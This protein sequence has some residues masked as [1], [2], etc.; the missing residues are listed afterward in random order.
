[1]TTVSGSTGTPLAA[2]MPTTFSMLEL[3]NIN[4][5]NKLRAY[6]MKKGFVDLSPKVNGQ[7]TVSFNG[8]IAKSSGAT[9]I[10]QLQKLPA[11]WLM[12]SGHHGILYGSDYDNYLDATGDIDTE[13]CYNNNDLAGFFNNDYHHSRWEHSSRTDPNAKT[14]VNEIYCRTTKPASSTVAPFPQ[15][16]PYLPDNAADLAALKKKCKGIILSACNTLS[17]KSVR[18]YW[19]TN[20]PDA[21]IFGTLGKIP[22][23]LYVVNSLASAPS[24][25]REFW[26][27]PATFLASASDM[28]QT[29]IAEINKRA[30]T[31]GIAILMIYKKRAYLHS[32]KASDPAYDFPHDFEY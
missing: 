7:A 11:D 23:G 16:N 12:L 27:N 4:D 26:E 14:N 21:V 6:F 32:G 24:T 8:S 28:P 1:M 25:T 20:Y 18:K 5:C 17:Y 29:I 3:S 13:K 9:F 15:N 22:M 10:S 2:V 30:R 19:V 31:Y